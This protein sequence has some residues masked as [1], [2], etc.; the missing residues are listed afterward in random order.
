MQVHLGGDVVGQAARDFKRHLTLDFRI[1]QRQKRGDFGEQAKGCIS[2]D[3]G[4][5][6]SRQEEGKLGI[7]AEPLQEFDAL[8]ERAR[9]VCSF[10]NGSDVFFYV[11]LDDVYVGFRV[12][13]G[14]SC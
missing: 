12:K 13:K 6:Q 2:H 8:G 4:R 14:P 7:I 5:N 9:L 11:G 10:L 3:D 1:R